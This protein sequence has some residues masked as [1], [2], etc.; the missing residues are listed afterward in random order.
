MLFDTSSN[1]ILLA[2]LCLIVASPF[3]GAGTYNNQVKP[4]LSQHCFTCHGPDAKQRKAELRLDLPPSESGYTP[5]RLKDLYAR[6]LD[7][8]TGVA[9]PLELPVASA[10]AVALTCR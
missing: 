4:I 3:A 6:H 7:E 1:K 9:P 2:A 10:P 5:E 8:L